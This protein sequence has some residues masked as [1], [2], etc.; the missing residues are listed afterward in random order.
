MAYEIDAWIKAG[1]LAPDLEEAPEGWF[2]E[3]SNITGGW[4]FT[5]CGEG[6][7][8]KTLY[9]IYTL[10]IADPVRLILINGSRIELPAKQV[11]NLADFLSRMLSVK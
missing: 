10:A 1:K 3:F 7:C 6:E 4:S 9:T 5:I 8:L 2:K 11:P